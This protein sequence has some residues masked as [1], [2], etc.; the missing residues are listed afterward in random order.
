[1]KKILIIFCLIILSTDSFSQNFVNGNF[2]EG[3]N[4]GWIK[5][6]QRGY[7][8]IG[9][10]DFFSS[11]EITPTVYPRSGQ[12]MARLGGF[13]YE[14]NSIYQNVT[15]PNSEKVYLGLYYQTRTSNISECSGLWVGAQIRVYAAGQVISDSYLCHYNDVYDWTFAYFDL[16]AAAGQTIQVG[17]R[18][19]AANSVWS[20]IYLDDVSIMTSLT[21]I[22]D[23]IDLPT[24]FALEQNYPNP[25]NPTTTIKFSIPNVETRHGASLQHVSLKVFDMLGREVVTL[26]NEKKAPGNYEV[27]F[28]ASSLAS[29]IYFYELTSGSFSQT[30]K[31]ILIK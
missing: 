11:T 17:F 23:E 1:M 18:A 24:K 28:D 14:I 27:K 16:S 6:S 13:E 2:E 15:L 12:Y 10:A 3:V 22:D 19:D 20:F 4:V 7:G 9:T 8:L 5:Y 30:K 26:V 25:F 29:G 21:G 31:F